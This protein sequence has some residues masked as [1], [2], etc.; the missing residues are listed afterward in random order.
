[1]AGATEGGSEGQAPE[2]G[3]GLSEGWYEGVERSI[4]ACPFGP[5]EATPPLIR[6]WIDEMEEKGMGARYREIHCSYL[7]SLIKISIKS[8]LLPHEMVNPFSLVDF[9]T[10]QVKH[11]PPFLEADYRG[12]GELLPSLPKPQ[13]LAMLVQAMTGARYSEF[14][15]RDAEDFDLDAGTLSIQ[16]EPE[17]GKAVKNKH[18]IRVIP[19][20]RFLVEQLRDFDFKWHTLDIVNKKIKRVNPKLSSHSFRHGMIRVNRDLGGDADAMEVY[21]GHRLAGM[22][23]T[24][25]DGYS[26]ERLREVATPCWEQIQTW[27]FN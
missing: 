18:S 14:Y 22:K 11:I 1:M 10:D 12:L 2:E 23:A 3:R 15:R 4:K 16:H 26:V 5:K 9:S 7:R 21:T 8:G 24:Y 13:R 17:K 25:G 6:K 27:L 20:P 19:L